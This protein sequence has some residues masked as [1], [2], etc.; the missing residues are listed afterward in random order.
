[1]EELGCGF[2]IIFGSEDCLIGEGHVVGSVVLV[3]AVGVGEDLLLVEVV[4]VLG[5]GVGVGKGFAGLDDCLLSDF[6]LVFEL[7]FV[8]EVIFEFFIK[9]YFCYLADSY[10]FIFFLISNLKLIFIFL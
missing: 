3:G 9:G 4:G 5:L 6:G 10:I 2:F 1:V 7:L 8:I